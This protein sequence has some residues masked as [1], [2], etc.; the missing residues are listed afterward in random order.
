MFSPRGRVDD[1]VRLF[2]SRPPGSSAAT[3]NHPEVPA[4]HRIAF[5]VLPPVY[6]FDLAIARM[7][8]DAT[9]SYELITCTVRPG[10]V[11]AFGGPDVV[12]E[13]DLSATERAD[14]VIVIGGG[15]AEADPRVLAAVR[16]ASA[17]G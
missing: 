13:D 15:G 4:M 1:D 8:L 9:T 11:E 16:A 10:R 12:V 5:L 17:A 3:A 14:T 2:R 7:V 6:A